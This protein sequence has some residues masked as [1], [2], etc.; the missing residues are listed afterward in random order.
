MT[1]TIT[2]ELVMWR[3]SDRMLAGSTIQ[4]KLAAARGPAILTESAAPYRIVA[5]NH[6]WR[7]LCGFGADRNPIGSTPAALQGELTDMKK[8]AA[9]RRD[10]LNYGESHAML[11]NYNVQSNR[12]FVHKIHA[13]KVSGQSGAEFYLTESSEVCD[14]RIRRAVL[15]I[16][17]STASHLGAIALAILATASLIFA[18]VSLASPAQPFMAGETGISWQYY[19]S[20]TSV[21]LVEC[22]TLGIPSA[23][24]LAWMGATTEPE[25]ASLSPSGASDQPYAEAESHGPMA[26][27]VVVCLVALAT[28]L[29]D[30]LLVL[31]E[32][33]TP[34]WPDPSSS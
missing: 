5:C 9:F 25:A 12:P 13:S 30:A 7:E 16:D 26:V 20:P 17:A 22:Y 3:A 19:M 2:D 21:N 29:L 28:A 23:C 15:K 32:E 1:V 34:C 6:A 24:P 31:H 14:A 27:F 11:A 10:L 4:K 8:A 33:I 18:Q